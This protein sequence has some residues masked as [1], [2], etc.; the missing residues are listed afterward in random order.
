MSS[1]EHTNSNMTHFVRN[2]HGGRTIYSLIHSNSPFIC[3]LVKNC[4]MFNGRFC[5]RHIIPIIDIWYIYISIISPIFHRDECNLYNSKGIDK[6]KYM[7]HRCTSQLIYDHLSKT[8]WQ[9][10]VLSFLR[11][12]LTDPWRLTIDSNRGLYLHCRKRHMRDIDV[13]RLF[14][15]ETQPHHA[16]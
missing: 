7:S 2:D 15:E 16:W 11:K 4:T 5:S 13:E 6:N 14:S 8:S 1:Q 10:D 3:C 9:F 12:H